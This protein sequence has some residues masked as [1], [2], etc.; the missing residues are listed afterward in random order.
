MNNEDGNDKKNENCIILI[1]KGNSYCRNKSSAMGPRF[2][3]SSE[4]LSAEIDIPLN[5]IQQPLT[6]VFISYISFNAS[7]NHIMIVS[8]CFSYLI[9]NAIYE[10]N[11]CQNCFLDTR[12]RLIF[13]GICFYDRFKCQKPRYTNNQILLS[14]ETIKINYK[15]D[16]KSPNKQDKRKEVSTVS[17]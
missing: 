4:G 10:S 6:I 8:F 16:K 1:P 3:V 12:I 14:I 2:K 5:G 7:L 15:E 11:H 9:N 13:T 17:I